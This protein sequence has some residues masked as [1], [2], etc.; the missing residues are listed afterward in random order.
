MQIERKFSRNA[1]PITNLPSTKPTQLL[2]NPYCL[3]QPLLLFWP[4]DHGN[5]RSQDR[6]DQPLTQPSITVNNHCM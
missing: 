4:F 6:I 5:R 2:R 3:Q 1:L